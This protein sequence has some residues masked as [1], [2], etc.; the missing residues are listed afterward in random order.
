MHIQ[1]REFVM[2]SGNEI[3]QFKAQAPP[4]KIEVQVARFIHFY[5]GATIWGYR[6]QP[7]E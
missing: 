6:D 2:G 4:E 1:K 7:R 3:I 5:E